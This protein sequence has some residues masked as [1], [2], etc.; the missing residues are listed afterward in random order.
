MTYRVLIVDDNELVTKPLSKMLHSLG[1]EVSVAHSGLEA[2]KIVQ[3]KKP[4]IVLLDIG[5]SKM[6]GYDVARNIRKNH[7]FSEII[8]VALTGNSRAQHRLKARE[9]GFDHH[10][11]KP[12][13]L[14]E[15]RRILNI[16]DF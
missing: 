14:V 10:L 15:I 16:Y 1:Y 4:K 7:K 12:A 6:N 9:A 11:D 8:L 2:L 3:Q 5:M 13:S